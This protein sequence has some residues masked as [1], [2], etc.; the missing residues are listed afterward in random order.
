M[1]IGVL[2][3]HPQPPSPMLLQECSMWQKG[4]PAFIKQG[5]HFSWIT[6]QTAVDLTIKAGFPWRVHAATL[7]QTCSNVIPCQAYAAPGLSIYVVD[8]PIWQQAAF[9]TRLFTFLCLLQ[10]A[11]PWTLLHALGHFPAPYLAVYTARFLGLPVVVS[12]DEPAL[13]P[14]PRYA[15]AWS[16]AARHAT[17]ALVRSPAD[18]QRLITTAGIVATKVRCLAPHPQAWQTLMALYQSMLCPET[19]LR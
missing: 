14:D 16:W 9:H 8:Q 19:S 7:P 12:Y 11:S 18:R 1:H 3:Y 5:H 10:R 15:F 4:I 6:T 2:S 17:L 13:C